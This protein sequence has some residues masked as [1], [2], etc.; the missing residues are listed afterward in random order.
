MNEVVSAGWEAL[1]RGAWSDALGLL[2]DAGDDPEALEGAGLA[3]WWLDNADATV[4]ARERAY[5]LY[6][7][8]GDALGAARV[9][10]ELA[11]DSVLF[12][13]RLVVA[14]GWLD[15]AAR[16]LAETD[17]APEHAWLAVREAEVALAAGEPAAAKDLS[18]IH[19]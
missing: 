15:R 14:R 18:L 19:I 3:H 6:R 5:R 10:G 12:G 7:E 9:A 17:P 4:D 8:R 1:A 13:S 11:W 2:E 16:L